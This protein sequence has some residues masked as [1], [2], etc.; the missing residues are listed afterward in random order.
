MECL[1]EEW[2]LPLAKYQ[3]ILKWLPLGKRISDLPCLVKFTPNITDICHAARAANAGGADG[4]SLINTVNSIVSV[5]LDLMAPEPTIDGKGSHGGY[6][7]PA[8][9]PMALFMVTEI[10]KDPETNN[11]PISAIGGISNWRDATEFIVMGAGGVQV[12]TAVMHYGFKIVDD[13]I[14]GLNNW[15]D[16]KGYQTLGGFQKGSS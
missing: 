10:A 6:C 14:D 12:C 13:M 4:V 5:D 2:V 7:G 8:V 1:K 16:E 9:K 3:N 15:M 11:L